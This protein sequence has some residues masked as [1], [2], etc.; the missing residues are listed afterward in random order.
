MSVLLAQMS[1][2][3]RK[4]NAARALSEYLPP[5]IANDIVTNPERLGLGGERKGV[6]AL[7]TDL[8]GSTTLCHGVEPTR[9]AAFLNEYLEALSQVILGHGGTIDKF[10]GDAV[11]AF[12][13]APVAKEDDGVRAVRSAPRSLCAASRRNFAGAI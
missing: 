5:E 7:F 2:L 6:F 13:G 12:W 4:L 9:M 1:R 3:R 10:V 11:V 8:E